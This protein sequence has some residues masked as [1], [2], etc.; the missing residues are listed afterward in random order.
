MPDKKDSSWWQDPKLILIAV[1]I[2]TGNLDKLP[3]LGLPSL[4]PTTKS[5]QET[6]QATASLWRE[7]GKNREHE[8]ELREVLW[9]LRLEL[10]AHGVVLPTNGPKPEDGE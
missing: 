3:L 7:I 2:A 9:Q 1:A 10:A 8:A 6:K 4:V 5:E